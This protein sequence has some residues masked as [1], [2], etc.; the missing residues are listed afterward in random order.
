[1]K[2]KTKTKTRVATWFALA[3]GITAATSVEAATVQITLNQSYTVASATGFIDLTGDG[4]VDGMSFDTG[5]AA[6]YPEYYIPGNTFIALRN[7]S[8]APGGFDYAAVIRWYDG[9][10]DTFRSSSPNTTGASFSD[11]RI[12]GGALTFG[13]LETTVGTDSLTAVRLVFNNA[14]TVAPTGPLAA[15]YPEFTTVPEPSALALLGLGAVG[16][17]T[18]RRR[19]G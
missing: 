3:M 19:V 4:V 1:M 16:L 11:S 5:Y 8:A 14:S 6:G 13:L 2:M 18:R 17:A 7:P 10:W 12:N 9:G 15:S